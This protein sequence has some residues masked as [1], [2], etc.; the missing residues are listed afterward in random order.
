MADKVDRGVVLAVNDEGIWVTCARGMKA[1]AAREFQEL[2]EEV[3]EK[4]GETPPIPD[5]TFL[6]D[7][8]LIG[9]R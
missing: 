4:L 6:L 9:L 2:C 7:V 1:R 3:C 5:T 8:K